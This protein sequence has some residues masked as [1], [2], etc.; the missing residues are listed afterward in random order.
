MNQAIIDRA[1]N[2]ATKA[3]LDGRLVERIIWVAPA[4]AMQDSLGSFAILTCVNLSTS[5]PP[6][7]D[8]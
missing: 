4:S 8:R 3:A 5:Q 7:W 6:P 2:L 1:V